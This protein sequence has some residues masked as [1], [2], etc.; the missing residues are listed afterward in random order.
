M[1]MSTWCV[2]QLIVEQWQSFINVFIEFPANSIDNLDINSISQLYNSNPRKLTEVQQFIYYFYHFTNVSGPFQPVTQ[3]QQLSLEVTSAL[4]KTNQGPKILGPVLKVVVEVDCEP[5]GKEGSGTSR[6]AACSGGSDNLPGRSDQSDHPNR[7]PPD[8]IP[9]EHEHRNG[10]R[11]SLPVP[12][13]C[14]SGHQPFRSAS[15]AL[16]T[17]DK[18]QRLGLEYVLISVAA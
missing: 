9:A 12:E 16:Q 3:S 17:H 7:L 4:G 15:P 10:L 13:L 8:F 6:C 14:C 5:L 18:S 2:L 11:A 1:I